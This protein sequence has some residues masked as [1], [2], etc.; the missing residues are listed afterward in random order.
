MSQVYY[1]V[2]CRHREPFSQRMVMFN[3][4]MAS[5]RAVKLSKNE[6]KSDSP[7]KRN[8]LKITKR[9]GNFQTVQTKMSLRDITC[10][11]PPGN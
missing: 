9:S 10:H 3:L 2:T 4:G 5:E 7:T 6:G 8:I 1:G 11:S